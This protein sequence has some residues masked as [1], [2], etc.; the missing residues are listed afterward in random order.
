MFSI[1]DKFADWLLEILGL[2]PAM[3]EQKQLPKVTGLPACWF[4]NEELA[5]RKV[6]LEYPVS[7][8]SGFS[9]S[10]GECFIVHGIKFDKP[11]RKLLVSNHRAKKIPVPVD[12]FALLFSWE[13]KLEGNRN[14]KTNR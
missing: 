3:K 5:G 8:G 4:S 7:L 13:A 12:C 2:L 14:G 9:L 11:L 1:L 6:R 10:A